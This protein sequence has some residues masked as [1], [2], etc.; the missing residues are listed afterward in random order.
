MSLLSLL[1]ACAGE[2][3]RA[4]TDSAPTDTLAP[5]DSADTGTDDTGGMPA[6]GCRAARGDGD[7]PRTVLVSLPYDENGDRA[8][9]WAVLTLG[10]DGA[11]TDD[12]V[13]VTMGRATAGEA[14]FTPDGS[15][16]LAPTERGALA[17]YDAAAGA[18]VDTAWDGGFYAERVVMDPSGEAAYVVDGNWPD[19]GGGLWRVAI[20]CATGE[21]SGAERLIEAKNPADLVLD[22]AVAYFAGREVPGAGAGAD[23]ARIDGLAEGAPAV[24]DGA[25]AFG[26]EEAF[27]SAAAMAGSTVLIADNNEFSG[28]P[29][30]VARVR[31]GDTLSPEAPVEVE[32]PVALVPFPDGSARAL[33]ASGYGDAL[34]ILD[35]DAGSVAR[36]S[37]RSVQ[38][39]SSM[40]TVK[41]GPLAGLVLVSEVGGVRR[42]QLGDD[43]VDLGVLG[44]GS[45]LDGLPGAIGVA[46]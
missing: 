6:D 2:P 28:Y 14:V 12:G 17:V 13:R 34:Y 46:P 39:P 40:A 9:A 43:A 16:A 25:D 21:L 24:R 1:L 18:V 15:L 38:L 20:D 44:F 30:R 3:R 7:G 41:R 33:L 10:T 36:V 31:V 19:N 4:G 27:V 45:G 11:L 35:A 32:D 29:T 42:V 22:G 5:D 8:D 37:A 26:D 23:L